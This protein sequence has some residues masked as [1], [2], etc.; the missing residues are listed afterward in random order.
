MRVETSQSRN[1]LSVCM[2]VKNEERYLGDCL[3]SIQAVADQLIVVDTGSA[4]NT[5]AIAA[6]FEAEV[7]HFKW[8]DDFAKARNESIQYATCDWILWLD[9]D[10]KL[11]SESISELRSLMKKESGPVA[12][13]IQIDSVVKGASHLSTAHRL[14][15]NNYGISFEGR[16]HE[17]ISY[18]L[19][20]LGGEERFSTVLL[21]HIGYDNAY[22]E[23]A[24][25]AKRN[26]SLLKKM[27]A[28]DPANRYAHYTLGQQ[29]GLLRDHKSAVKHFRKA[30]RG[31][32]FEK[33][34][35]V[36]LLNAMAESLMELKQFDEAGILCKKSQGLVAEQ[37]GVY[38]ID[39]R[40]ALRQENYS[41]ALVK[42]KRL[43]E[44]NQLQSHQRKSISTDVKI[45]EIKVLQ[46]FTELY[47]RLGLKEE[48][49]ANLDKLLSCDPVNEKA[50]AMRIQL[51][52]ECGR[53]NDAENWLLKLHS[54]NKAHP[55]YR[56]LM[57][58]VLIKLQKFE[59]AIDFYERE[60]EEQPGDVLLIKRLV[61][62]HA[63]LG[64]VGVANTLALQL[65]PE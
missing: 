56:N 38:L 57:G 33:A 54:I 26:L 12:Y 30:M 39:Y 22:V 47:K 4:D 25:K 36:S 32:V 34:M 61:G 27:I 21:Q 50:L 8:C 49:E 64:H 48:L 52:V 14:F 16:I 59:Q 46:E 65:T 18:S 17:Q 45:P 6:D 19:F 23:Q 35:R 43:A 13:N 5:I 7:Y 55:L 11:S 2:I 40:L 37:V 63:K 28:D 62:L 53:F 51:D 10:E 60:L 41:E 24:G 3:S 44:K 15:T 31:N 20:A 42:L 1:T 9:A 29:Y 58:A